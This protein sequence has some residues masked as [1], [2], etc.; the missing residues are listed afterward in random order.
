MDT[1]IYKAD[2]VEN[3]RSGQNGN[4]NDHQQENEYKH[5]SP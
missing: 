3:A 4:S 5:E 2:L 1:N